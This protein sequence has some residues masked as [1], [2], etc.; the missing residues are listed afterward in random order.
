M[1]PKRFAALFLA[2]LM[3]AMMLAGCMTPQPKAPPQPGMPPQP[4][5][6][7]TGLVRIPPTEYPRFVD[8]LHY[9]RLGRGIEMSLAYLRKLP[10]DR[11]V[12]FGADSYQVGHIIRSLEVF[13]QIIKTEPSV[14]QL[15]QV[16][17]R[18]F[19]VYRSIGA[20]QSQKVLFTGY[21][22][23]LL[24][25][26][27]KPSAAFPVPIHSRPADLVDIDLSPFAADLQGR[28]IVGRY[29]GR[30][31]VPYPEREG[32][33]K[34]PDLARAAPPI[35]WLRDETDLFILMVQGSGRIVLPDGRTIQVQFDSSNGRPYRSIGRMLIDQGEIEPDKMS[36]QTLRDYLRRN[37]AKAEAVLNYNPR[38]IFFHQVTHGPI[39]A[40][41][42]PLTS[43]RSIAVDRTIFPSAAL[44]F[45]SF[46]GPVADSGGTIQEW[47]PFN[48]FAL[49]QDT[50]S[51]ITG[52]GRVDFFWGDGP[53][54]E[55]CAGHL[56]H[57]GLLFF[58][59]LD[60]AATAA[61]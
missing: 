8:Q 16:L 21:Y 46:T 2:I 14:E 32:L 3:S 28:H 47:A 15:N 31:V 7:Q 27:L 51:A 54:A 60:P 38:Y 37:P 20:P 25:G 5:A 52:P 34:E 35:A 17:A 29:T 26:S 41:G 12:Q 36:M 22:E 56:K 33:R 42:V 61:R 50:G 59:V 9:E 13:A 1:I 23:P 10:P 4:G 45:V 6:P 24:Q 49:A 43:E 19:A 55:A 40:L 44:A 39:G 18:R 48:G 53:R 11:P 57:A 30:T 58:L